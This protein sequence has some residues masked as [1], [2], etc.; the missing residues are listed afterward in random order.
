LCLLLGQCAVER[1]QEFVNSRVQFVRAQ[2]GDTL[3]YGSFVNE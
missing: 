2:I 1:I 3:E